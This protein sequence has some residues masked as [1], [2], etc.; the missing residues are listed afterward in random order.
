M[1]AGPSRTVRGGR[2]KGWLTPAEV[3][4]LN[5]IISEAQ[6]ILHAGRP[7]KGARCM[8]LGF[9]LAPARAKQRGSGKKKA[10][11]PESG[12]GDNSTGEA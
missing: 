7:R 2:S 9:V 1:T 5:A 10:S 6:E 11:T 4:R 12:A 8:S 3:R